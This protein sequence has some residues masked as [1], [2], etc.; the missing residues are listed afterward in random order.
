[1]KARNILATLLLTV[2]GLQTSQAQ[3]LTTEGSTK[4]V[5]Y[6]A[7][8]KTYECSI[9]QLDSIVF[10]EEPHF[11]EVVVTVDTNGYAD[12][13][14]RFAKIDETSFYIDDIMYTAQSGHLIV[15]GYNQAFFTGEAI[16]I[17]TLKYDG[18]TLKVDGIA[19]EAFKNC[20]VL[21]SISIPNSVASIGNDAFSGCTSLTTVTLNSNAIMSASRT[22]NT[23]MKYMFG[24]QVKTYVIGD[25]VKSIGNSAFYGCTNLLSITIPYSINSIGESAFYGCTN[26]PS[27]TI[28]YSVT[29]IGRD[30]FHGC[31]FVYDSFINNSSLTSDTNWGAIL[32]DVETDEGL[33][34]KGDTLVVRCR[35]WAT[36]AT[37]PNSV[38]RINDYAFSNCS[39]LTSVTIPNSVTSIGSWAFSSCNGLTSIMIPSR[40]TSIGNNAFR[41]C[42]GLTS[43]DIPNSVTTINYA[44]FAGCTSLTSINIPNNVTDLASCAFLG[45]T[46]LTTVNIG[47][48]VTSINKQTFK[49][50]TSLT[51]ITIPN[52][53]TSIGVEAFYYCT[54]MTYIAIPNSVTSIGSSAFRKCSGLT[55]V[56]IP[57]SVTSIDK[58]AFRDCSGL[59]FITIGSGVT[60]IGDYAFQDCENLTD[61][62]CYAKDIPQTGAYVFYGY[63]ISSA[64]LHV[65]ASSVNAY[66]TT[67]PWRS[68]K[69]IVAIQ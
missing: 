31:F 19:E 54:S 61:V 64:T 17:S 47:S 1:M 45:C 15:S 24:S 35:L 7:G 52:S 41:D 11:Q 14:H 12:G 53:V 36:S 50:C 13:G 66:K 56:T 44:T 29:N 57:N 49:E 8:D 9:S 27:I 58:Y 33:L 65:P 42:S 16:I 10:V 60:N 3:G 48:G 37:I 32:S 68:F 26:L 62:Y 6:M 23:S 51:N 67:E 4:V 34:I 55:F 25:A 30:A 39:G 63:Y 20:E 18:R 2:A 22:W 21:T 43:F 38:I 5:L 28:P 40:V 69:N 59:T 46:G